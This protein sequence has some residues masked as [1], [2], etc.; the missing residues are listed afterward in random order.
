[1]QDFMQA[2]KSFQDRKEQVWNQWATEEYPVWCESAPARM[3]ALYSESDFPTLAHCQR[4]FRC[5]VIV[6]PLAPSD[7]WRRVA[8]ISPD[9]AATMEATQN[10]AVQRAI[11][12]SHSALWRE[13]M[14]RIQHISDELSKEKPKIHESLLGNVISIVEL[15][16]AYNHIHNDQRLTDLAAQVKERLA[17][18]NVVDL[19][20]DSEARATAIQQAQVIVNQF[21]PYARSFELD[22][23][24][25]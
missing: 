24:G 17:G 4:R 18:I 3:G 12:E 14:E 13:V 2:S 21:Q 25:E 15:I 6:M 8:M 23:D 11:R 7:Q 16:P 19:R 10:E 1:V 9:L 22:D 20:K 5:D